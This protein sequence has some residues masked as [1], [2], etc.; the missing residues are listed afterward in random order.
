MGTF[1]VIL[2]VLVLVKF[3]IISWILYVVFKPDIKQVWMKKTKV[4]DVPA[5]V[6]CRSRWT[7]AVDEGQTRWD[8]D[9]L[10]LVTTYECEH[11]HLPFWHIERVPMGSAKR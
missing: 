5:C 10:V 2:L 7:R 3:V 4:P 8:H 6:Y 1:V 9:D 11:C